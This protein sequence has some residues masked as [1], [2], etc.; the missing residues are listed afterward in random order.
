MIFAFED[1]VLDT[2]RCTLLRGSE[3][4]PLRPKAYDLLLFLLGRPGQLASKDEIY[5]QLWPDVTVEETSLTQCVA[6][7][8]RAL[9]PDGDRLIRTVPRR[10]YILEADVT[11][12]PETRARA[13]PNWRVT[14]PLASAFLAGVA[15]MWIAGVAES[16]VNPS[17]G[18]FL[19]SGE[20]VLGQPIVYPEGPAR[21]VGGVK[22]LQPGV[23]S[24]VHT[25]EVPLFAYVLE[26]EVEIDYGNEGIRRYAPGT[27][28]VEAIDMPHDARS[29]GPE[30]ARI[31]VL[32]IRGD[33]SVSR[34]ARAVVGQ[35]P[36]F[37]E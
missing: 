11:T 24:G 1:F 34:L 14:A 2:D 31:L 36:S 12:I 20:T 6:N 5:A 10:G 33:G 35:E 9:S 3:S 19:D 7:L 29:V 8:R 15:F 25:H 28:F 17:E 32:E 4:I 18:I 26:G 37:S 21:L 13:F 27:G 30:T 16:W 23:R 22:T